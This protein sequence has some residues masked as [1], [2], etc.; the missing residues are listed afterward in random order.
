[1]PRQLP[2]KPPTSFDTFAQTHVLPLGNY[3]SPTNR[4]VMYV[5]QVST[6]PLLPV[7]S[8]R[9]HRPSRSAA[10]SFI[11]TC[12]TRWHGS[13]HRDF[14]ALATIVV[15]PHQMRAGASVV[16]PR[17]PL[18]HRAVRLLPLSF[19]CWHDDR[20]SCSGFLDV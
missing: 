11:A 6:P 20:H 9:H 15:Q 5:I 3:K 1:V 16:G 19:Y 8:A 4:Q 13:H 17:Q 14:Q 12:L 18:H 10:R 2:L 7:K